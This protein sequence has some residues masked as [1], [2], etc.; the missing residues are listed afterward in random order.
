MFRTLSGRQKIAQV[1]PFLLLILVTFFPIPVVTHPFTIPFNPLALPSVPTS[2]LNTTLA[3][4]KPTP[5][6]PLP[7]PTP[8]P[9]NS[10]HCIT[11][12]RLFPVNERLCGPILSV[13]YNSDTATD[14]KTYNEALTRFGGGGCHIDLKKTTGQSKIT[15]TNKDVVGYAVTVMKECEAKSGAGWLQI[16]ETQPWYL[17]VY[18]DRL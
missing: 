1:A 10:I 16:F 8:G 13:L 2:S 14:P 18:G 4:P 17:L 5:K 3:G 11:K 7:P 15:I 6:S 12:P 9:W